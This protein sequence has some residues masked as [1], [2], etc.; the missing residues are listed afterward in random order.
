M[1]KVLIP[2]EMLNGQN[3][4]TK[5]NA[6]EKFDYTSIA[7]RLRTVSLSKFEPPNWCG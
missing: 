6:T 7:D 4:N 3:D 5:N 2:T 1:T